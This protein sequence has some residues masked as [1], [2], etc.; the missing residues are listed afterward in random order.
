[1]LSSLIAMATASIPSGERDFGSLQLALAAVP[2]S[3]ARHG[4]R[5][6]FAEL[7]AVVVAAVFSGARTLT[8]IAEWADHAAS[9]RSFPQRQDA[10][11]CDPAPGDDHDRYPRLLTRSARRPTA[12]PQPGRRPVSQHSSGSVSR[13]PPRRC[14]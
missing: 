13:A 8:M 3:R 4:V 2:D 5:Y 1:M 11:G 6:T 14:G 12:A 7:L 10:L 9:V